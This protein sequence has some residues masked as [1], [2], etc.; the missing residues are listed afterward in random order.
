MDQLQAMRVFRQVGE[1]QSFSRAADEL[2]LSR[3]A[4]S[5]IVSGLE[6]QLGVRLLVRT[7]RRVTLTVEGTAY[8]D[9]CRDIL[10]R[11]ADA[12]EE[13]SGA[14]SRP[15][16]RIRVDVPIV[17]GRLVLAPNLAEFARRYPEIALD[18]RMNDRIVDLAREGVDV[19]VRG[20]EVHGAG[21]LVRRIATMRGFTCASPAYL[22]ECGEPQTPADLLHHR[23]IAS[24]DEA[25]QPRPW[26][27]RI[28]GQ[29]VAVPV[30]G[31]YAF[32]AVDTAFA[33]AVGGLGLL[34]TI[35]MMGLQPRAQ[36]RLVEVLADYAAPGPP[37]SLVYPQA[38]PLPARLRI[39]S[40]FV[41]DLM[42]RLQEQ[43]RAARKSGRAPQ[44]QP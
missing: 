27:F 44:T 41:A 29:R 32:N 15:A 37:L 10:T 40:D 5:T 35:D 6:R 7:T 16:G 31:Q 34:Q 9:R 19:A 25:G 3:G 21:L 42:A 30:P 1:R 14:R 28:K 22:R 26:H 4:I 38:G 20:G 23:C 11:V 17:F 36:G 33:A 13:V 43:T 12:H 8:L 24:L 39:F 2:G 18:I